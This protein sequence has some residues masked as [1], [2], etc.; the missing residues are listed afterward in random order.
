M[1]FQEVGS[2]IGKKG[3]IVKR[4]REDVS[5]NFILFIVSQQILTI[6]LL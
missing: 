1:M 4:F 5:F 3:D 6:L 2:I